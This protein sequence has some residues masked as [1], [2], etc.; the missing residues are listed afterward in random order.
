[1]FL[2]PEG[3]VAV[4]FSDLPREIGLAYA[5]KMP[6]H[7][8]V[9]FGGKLSTKS[10]YNIP[11]TY[12]FCKNDLVVPPKHQ[13]KMIDDIKKVTHSTVDVIELE[14][15]HGPHISQPD[16]VVKAIRESRWGCLNAWRDMSWAS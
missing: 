12:V 10:H 1:M 7:S 4:T 6:G 15:G 2:E 14:S 5:K 13:Q 16:N 9:S 8:A 11:I 3:N